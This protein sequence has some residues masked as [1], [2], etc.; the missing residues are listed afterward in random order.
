MRTL[1]RATRV[2]TLGHPSSGEWLLI[3]DRHVQRVGSGDLPHADRV[4]DLPGA[5]IMPG[6]V[7]AH[8]HLTSTGL[9]VDDEAVRATRSAADLLTVAR[10]RAE[11]AGDDVV[12]LSGFDESTWAD[13]TLPGLAALD[14]VSTAPL[15]IR[16]TDGHAALVNSGALERSGALAL[17][18]GVQRGPDGAPTGIVRRDANRMVVGWVAEQ[19]SAHRIEE[20]QLIAAGHAAMVGVTSVHEMALPHESGFRDVEVL[21]S[22]RR[23]LPIQVEVVLGTMD[24]PAAVGLGLSAIGGDLP[25]DGS[26]GARTA[27]LSA[28]YADGSGTGALA[29]DDDILRG[30]FRDAHDAGLQ[31]GMHAIGDRAIEQVLAAWEALARDLDSRQRRHLR[32]RRHRIEHL[33]MPSAGQIERAAML[34]IA[35]SIQPTFDLYWGGPGALY[36]QAVGH[37]RAWAMTPVRVLEERG[38]V[39]GVGSD[40]PV[41]PLDPWLTI[42]ALEQHHDQSQRLSRRDAIRLHT[43]GSARLA[44]REGKVGV[45]EPGMRADFAAYDV[46][47][48]GID[49][50]QGLRPILTVSI[51]REVWLA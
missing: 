16:R 43:V 42:H 26:I 17:R 24:V 13:Q 47:P 15:V 33:E 35:A 14:G 10:H 7:D 8:V 12:F 2:R 34:G 4:V 29:F 23:R 5:T 25:A 3:D 48:F 32:A 9:A 27:A 11:G 39:V 18:D 36:E 37:A 50:V 20:L 46:D 19:R 40:S 51:G 30:F 44:H 1:Y 6:F 38:V 28:P 31:V 49:D 21:L 45:L 22:H 41:V